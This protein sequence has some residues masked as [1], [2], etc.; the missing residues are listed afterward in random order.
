MLVDVLKQLPA[1]EKLRKYIS[2]LVADQTGEFKRT[3]K[4]FFV[5]SDKKRLAQKFN[6]L[7]EN[8]GLNYGAKYNLIEVYALN[9]DEPREYKNYNFRKSL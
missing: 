3:I 5:G 8:Y 4:I 6:Q 2:S 7:L 9:K 1:N